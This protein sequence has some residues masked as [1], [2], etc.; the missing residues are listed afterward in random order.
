[1]KSVKRLSAV[2]FALAMMITV[3]GAPVEA[4]SNIRLS[5]TS[6]TLEKG[7]TVTLTVKG[8]TKKATWSTSNKKVAT[9]TQKGKVTAKSK[10][11]ANIIAKVAKKK[12][13]CSVKVTASKAK[14]PL[15]QYWSKDSY[16]CLWSF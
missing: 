4:K 16:Q 2:F 8:T 10:G 5:R 9:V 3:A 15:S 6:V 12:L 11:S 1:M 14:T 7:K 13:K